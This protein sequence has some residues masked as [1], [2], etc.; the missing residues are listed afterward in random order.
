[1]IW[2]G[3]ASVKNLGEGTRW[4]PAE[5]IRLKRGSF[6][7][8]QKHVNMILKDPNPGW[9]S[10]YSIHIKQHEYIHYRTYEFIDCLDPIKQCHRRPIAHQFLCCQTQGR[11]KKNVHVTLAFSPVGDSFR[12]RL[13]SWG[14]NW[15]T[16]PMNHGF[17]GL[18]RLFMGNLTI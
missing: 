11:V 14:C 18:F 12:N 8:P 15:W 9:Y 16:D 4:A 5:F 7:A 10:I 1:M 17:T 3:A 2:E 6:T 13:R